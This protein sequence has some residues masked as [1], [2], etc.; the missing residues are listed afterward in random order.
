M[1]ADTYIMYRTYMYMYAVQYGEPR[2]RYS[3]MHSSSLSRA[4][5][6][7]LLSACWRARGFHRT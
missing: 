1:R 6:R 2:D 5:A 3:R 7:A 4:A